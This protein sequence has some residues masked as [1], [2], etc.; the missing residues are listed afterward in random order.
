ML[1]NL[2]I[3]QV[4]LRQP[5]IRANAMRRLGGRPVLEWV[6]RRVTD[7]MRLDGVIVLVC[8]SAD[9][10]AVERLV[11]SDVPIFV[12]EGADAMSHFLRALEEYPAEGVVRVQG[13][14]IFVDPALI[15]RLATTA[16]SQP[17]ADYV[18]Y[19]SR[20]GRPAILTPVGVY[21]EWF[22]AAALRRADRLAR[23][24]LD[25]ELVTRY[26]YTHPDKFNVLLL[27]APSRI[28]RDDVRLTVDIEEDWDL[29]LSFFEAL[30]PD[31]FDWQRIASLLDHHPALRSRMAALNR[32]HARKEVGV[33]G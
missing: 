13:D 6:I 25:R 28:D 12:A 1:G 3:V 4:C 9:R 2:G 30:G 5:R 7:S 15:D 10:A 32:A 22:R 17:D 8:Q 18:G 21:A 14:N 20:D 23:D 33:G 16:A 11:P 26:L 19:F 31:G 29:V 27:P 24:K